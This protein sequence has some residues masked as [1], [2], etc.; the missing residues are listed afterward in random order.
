MVF[1]FP[2]GVLHDTVC[3]PAGRLIGGSGV[4]P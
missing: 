3:G 1:T 4:E 2:E